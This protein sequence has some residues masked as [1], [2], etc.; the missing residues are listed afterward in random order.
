MHVLQC[1]QELHCDAVA[2]AVGEAVFLNTACSPTQ[3]I[4]EIAVGLQESEDGCPTP[5]VWRMILDEWRLKGRV[6]WATVQR[7]EA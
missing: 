6:W 5:A 2:H 4:A 1:G 3:E 7:R